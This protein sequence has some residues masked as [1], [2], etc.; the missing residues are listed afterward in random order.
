MEKHP[1]GSLTW[2]DLSS[3]LPIAIEREDNPKKPKKAAA[4]KK[5]FLRGHKYDKSKFIT[6]GDDPVNQ[7]E[8]ISEINQSVVSFRRAVNSGDILA[9]TEEC[10]NILE[11]MENMG[12]RVADLEAL[13]SDLALSKNK[14]LNGDKDA[15]LV[16]RFRI[17]NPAE[18]KKKEEQGHM[19]SGKIRKAAQ[20]PGTATFI[21]LIYRTKYV[22]A[23]NSLGAVLYGLSRTKLREQLKDNSIE[24]LDL[25]KMPDS[26]K[27]SEERWVS[28]RSIK[29]AKKREEIKAQKAQMKAIKAEA[30]EKSK[31]KKEKIEQPVQMTD[32]E[33]LA[34]ISKIK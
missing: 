30:K 19:P 34:A 14:Y 16:L 7:A 2:P 1:L 17:G 33:L 24:N 25:T 10:L 12:V 27:R 9:E 26:F 13:K 23:G 6:I 22:P 3:G 28:K 8:A 32:E 11:A 21:D 29:N 31:Q 4:P 5:P 20:P 15:A 18:P